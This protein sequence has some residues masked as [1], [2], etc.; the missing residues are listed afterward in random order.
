MTDQITLST[1]R[2]LRWVIRTDEPFRGHTQSFLMPD[3]TVAYT[4][5][6]TPEEYAAERGYE[7]KIVSDA[8]LDAMLKT[9]HDSMCNA[10]E[11]E[12]EDAYFDALNVLPP[13]RWKVV[14]GVEMFHVSESITADLVHWH[15]KIG[16]RFF[17]FIDSMGARLEDLADKVA[18]ANTRLAQE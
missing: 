14:K 11:V 16:E 4:Q 5:G 9:F 17:T 13:M 7:I 10:P 8:E 6:Q 3:G 12:T 15:A 1:T 2:N 18:L